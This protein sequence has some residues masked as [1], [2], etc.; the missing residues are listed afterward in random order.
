MRLNYTWTSTV[1]E[2]ASFSISLYKKGQT[3]AT[4]WLFNLQKTGTTF[5]HNVDIANYYLEI[6]EANLDYWTVTI[7]V[8]IEE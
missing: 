4:E 6:S 2:F 7:E 8:F 3:I 1:E 5:V